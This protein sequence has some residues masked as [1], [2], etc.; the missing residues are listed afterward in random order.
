MRSVDRS[1]TVS[2]TPAAACSVLIASATSAAASG[3]ASAGGASLRAEPQTCEGSVTAGSATSTTGVAAAAS[4]SGA[5]TWTS[6]TRSPGRATWHAAQRSVRVASTAEGPTATSTR[7]AGEGAAMDDSNQ[8]REAK[9]TKRK[10]R[11]QKRS[12]E[13]PGRSRSKVGAQAARQHSSCGL[14]RQ[15]RRPRMLHMSQRRHDAACIITR[16][17]QSRAQESARAMQC[18]VCRRSAAQADAAPA[19]SNTA[20]S[21]AGLEICGPA[22]TR[23]SRSKRSRPSCGERE[24][25]TTRARLAGEHEVVRHVDEDVALRVL[26]QRLQVLA[27]RTS[28]YKKGRGTRRV[29]ASF[30]TPRARAKARTA[31]MPI[32]VV[33]VHGAGVKRRPVK[34]TW[35]ITKS[36]SAS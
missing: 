16:G 7:R 34:V 25:N 17:V 2:T 6:E 29:S 19:R 10:G 18:G 21:R 1:S 30:A 8:E 22:R 20:H 26:G 32:V 28:R 14:P 11:T 4:S 33:G 13:E 35:E 23:V 24:C 27:W 15:R 31:G 9:R 3:P 12:P 36:K 5:R